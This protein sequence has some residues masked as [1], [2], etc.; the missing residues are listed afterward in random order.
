LLREQGIHVLV[1]YVGMWSYGSTAVAAASAAGVPAVVL[2]DTDVQYVGIV[3]AS[4]CR[5]SL[6]EAGLANSLVYGEL[7]DPIVAQELAVRCLGAA[8]GTR[9]QGLTYGLMGST[10]LGMYTSAID[11]TQWRRKFGI[12]VESW[13]QLEVVERAKALPDSAVDHHL[14]WSRRV[15]G[16]I[17]VREEVMRAALKL[18]AVSKQIVSERGFDMVSVRCLPEM[19]GTYT[20]F[21]YTI[22]L[23][24]DTSDAEGGKDATICA[25]ESD[26][27]GALTMQVL[28]HL[29]G[30]PVLMADVR[31]VNLD[32][33][34]VWIS[35]C[36]SSATQL[37]PSRND[38]HWVAHG[39]EEYEWKLGG[40][41]P[42]YVVR[43]G[44]VTL[45]RLTRD[46]GDYVMLIARGR[47]LAE[48]R[49]KLGETYWGF[50]PHAFIELEAEPREFAQALRCNHLHMVYGDYVDHLLEFCRVL[51]VRPILV[52]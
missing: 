49:E 48:P 15:F 42:Q 11:A 9:L 39:F 25:C 3:G 37:A 46:A 45:A 26:S 41:C 16:E 28:K 21:C 35:N 43:S 2:T 17:G 1:L 52:G 10:S 40:A 32:S 5:G 12:E 44:D 29:A 22:S 38:V 36:G 47:A 33:R 31:T 20:T 34:Q 51:D 14:D 7:D 50:S 13:D 4:V 19:P 23:L 6:E 30:A 27:N 8:A 18:Y 24:N